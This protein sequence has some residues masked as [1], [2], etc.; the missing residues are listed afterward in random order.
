MSTTGGRV[1][2]I[3]R[4]LAQRAA[5]RREQLQGKLARL[6]LAELNALRCAFPAEEPEAVEAMSDAE[7]AAA[8]ASE[9]LEQIEAE[10]ALIDALLAAHRGGATPEE[11]RGA[12]RRR[13]GGARRSPTGG[14]A[15]RTGERRL[16]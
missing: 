1:L 8:I 11:L 2:R 13:V 4:T 14:R 5:E 12:V 10:S 15:S 6:S 3:E 9:T 7:L 16:I